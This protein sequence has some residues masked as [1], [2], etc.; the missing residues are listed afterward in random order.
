MADSSE[1]QPFRRATAQSVRRRPPPPQRRA[2]RPASS[3]LP[4]SHRPPPPSRSAP[5]LSLIND[6][7]ETDVE[8]EQAPTPT[9]RRGRPPPPPL[10]KTISEPSLP[11]PRARPRPPPPGRMDAGPVTA[12]LS[13]AAFVE[14]EPCW[15]GISAPIQTCIEY[16][17]KPPALADEGL[18][19]IPGNRTTVLAKDKLLLASNNAAALDDVLEPA[20]VASLLK[21]LL[22]RHH[23]STGISRQSQDALGQCLTVATET[24]DQIAHL[25][26]AVSELYQQDHN[27]LHAMVWLLIQVIQDDANMM[28]VKALSTSVGP[29][30][31]CCLSTGVAQ[32]LVKLLLNNALDVMT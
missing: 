4:S 26:Q 2:P 5:A 9:S 19:R 6:Y 18:F 30:L 27:L 25:R 32:R 13:I 7:G 12:K 24:S 22:S 23:T 1:E 3:I 29:S 15:A 21:V 11:P 20:I 14:Q 28:S 31:F 17:A 8:P 16:L 10:Q